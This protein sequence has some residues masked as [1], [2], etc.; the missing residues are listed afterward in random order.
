MTD[1]NTLSQNTK[2][3]NANRKKEGYDKITTKAILT[4]TGTFTI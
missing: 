1:Y 2:D 4:L 3:E